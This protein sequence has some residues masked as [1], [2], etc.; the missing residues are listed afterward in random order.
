MTLCDRLAA[1]VW[2]HL[3]GDALG[4]PYEFRAPSAIDRLRWGEAGTHGQ[5]PGTWSDDG[6]LMLALLDSL[7]TAG[8]DPADQASRALATGATRTSTSLA[9]SLTSA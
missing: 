1:G 4:V 9:S 3:V 7:L 2:G 6:G 8:L 5:P